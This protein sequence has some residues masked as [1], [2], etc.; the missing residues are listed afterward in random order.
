MKDRKKKSN[1][2]GNGYERRIKRGRDGHGQEESLSDKFRAQKFF[3]SDRE[4]DW[5]MSKVAVAVAVVVE[6]VV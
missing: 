1:Q 4:T 5:K 3:L 6:V 2:K